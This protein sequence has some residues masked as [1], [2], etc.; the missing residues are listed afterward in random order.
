MGEE[1]RV[2][3]PPENTLMTF[4]TVGVPSRS[5]PALPTLASFTRVF[6]WVTHKRLPRERVSDGGPYI[7]KKVKIMDCNRAHLRNTLFL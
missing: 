2:K 4:P 3:A 5:L 6:L 1:E 7:M